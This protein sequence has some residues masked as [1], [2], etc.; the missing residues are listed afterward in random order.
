MGKKYE[1]YYPIVDAKNQIL[2]DKYAAKAKDLN[3]VWFVGRLGDYKY[4]NMDQTVARAL[5]LFK[6]I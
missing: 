5:E 6:E 4:Y 3:N 2:Y 1:R